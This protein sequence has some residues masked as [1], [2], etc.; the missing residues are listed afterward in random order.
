MELSVLRPVYEHE[1]PF[2]T[3]YLE[4]RSPSE[5]AHNQMRLRWKALRERLE[6]AGA[7]N[8]ALDA[9]GTA[10]DGGAAGEEQ[11]NGRVMVADASGV[12]LDEPWDAALGAGDDAHWTVLPELGAYVR[13]RARGVRALVVVA[14][15][16]GAVVRREVIARQHRPVVEGV[17]EVT[18]S[19]PEGMEKQRGQAHAHSRVQRRAEEVVQR[20]ARD[21]VEYARKA[22]ESFRP[23]VLVLAGEVQA[24]TAVRDEIGPDLLPLLT[25]TDR[26]GDDGHSPDGALA[27]E[28]LRIATAVDESVVKERTNAFREGLAHQEATEGGTPVAA[29]AESGAVDTL[30]FEPGTD[31]SREAFLIKVCAGTGAAFGLVEEGT[32]MHEGV[33]SLLRFPP[34]PS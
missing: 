30:L 5:D 18:G 4:G 29:A 20:N 23:D 33:G 11:T 16:E 1:G 34:V 15:Q 3:V 13:E 21:V 22:A 31:A 10:L 7:D 32:G 24:R 28:L 19:A 26:G 25:E 2:A 12:V 6:G 27:E 9:I 8:A 17:T 14:D